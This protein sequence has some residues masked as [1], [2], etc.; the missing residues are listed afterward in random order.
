MRSRTC[1]YHHVHP[2]P[3]ARDNIWY[4]WCIRKHRDWE[5]PYWKETKSVVLSPW[6]ISRLATGW[7]LEGL[8]LCSE[9]PDKSR[10]C[11][12]FC[13]YGVFIVKSYWRPPNPQAWML[14][15]LVRNCLFNIF[16]ATLHIRRLS[17]AFAISRTPPPPH[18]LSLR[19]GS[20]ITWVEK[21]VWNTRRYKMEAQR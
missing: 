6:K 5:L 14:S 16:S 9:K 20:H 3:P 12:T 13:V 19:Q 7:N 10:D 8:L 2:P 4:V 15:P 1:Y 17:P 21:T 18:S 11:V